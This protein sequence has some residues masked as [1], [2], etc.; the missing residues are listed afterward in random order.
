[1]NDLKECLINTCTLIQ[2]EKEREREDERNRM[3]ENVKRVNT[4]NN[5]ENI[6]G[7]DR[8]ENGRKKGTIRRCRE[9]ILKS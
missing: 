5:L 4:K 7:A 8:K 9:R 2:R 3:R 6:T 1:M